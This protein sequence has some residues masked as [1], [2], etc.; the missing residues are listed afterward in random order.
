MK[1]ANATHG[2]T[3]PQRLV[4]R[5]VAFETICFPVRVKQ[6]KSNSARVVRHHEYIE[7]RR[8]LADDKYT[9]NLDLSRCHFSFDL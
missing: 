3:N 5:V 4:L 2:A 7:R 6:L 8:Q 9:D 1:A